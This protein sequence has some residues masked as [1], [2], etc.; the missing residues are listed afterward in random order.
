MTG[1]RSSIRAD[2]EVVD[3]GRVYVGAEETRT[4]TLSAPG[5]LPVSYSAAFLGQALGFR[6]GPASARVAANGHLELTITFAPKV[7]A[8]LTPSLRLE[9]DATETPIVE[10]ALRGTGVSP[11][12]CEDG[13]GCTL[14]RFDLA[15]RRCVHE[16]QNWACDDLNPCTELD[17]CVE[18]LC[19]GVPRSCD[20]ENGCTD[21]VCD[22]STGC[23]HLSTRSCDD[24]NPCT[25]D[26]C[27]A[28][29]DCVHNDAELGTVCDSVVQCTIAGICVFGNCKTVD[30]PEG[31]PCDD[32]DPCTQDEQC[33]DHQCIQ[34]GYTPAAV[35]EVKFVTDVGPLA[36]TAAENPIIDRDGTVFLGLK[37]AIT[38]VD[39]CGF[40]G[41]T[42]ELDDEPR[43]SGAVALPGVLSVPVGQHVVDVDTRSGAV[44]GL[45]DLGMLFE[46]PIET[47]TTA[48]TTVEVVDLALRA[49]G[50]MMASVVRRIDRPLVPSTADSVNVETTWE[51]IIA[52]IDR[53]HR[54]ASVFLALGHRIA[55]R[56]A[57]DQ[58]ESI[59]A[60]LRETSTDE[61][62]SRELAVR[63][64][65]EGLANNSWAT[66]ATNAL[67]SD[68]A[69]SDR[70]RVFWSG[71][72]RRIEKDG[73]MLTLAVPTSTASA[74]L[75]GTPIL[76][77]EQLFIVGPASLSAAPDA[78]GRDDSE[79]RIS[80]QTFDFSG[81]KLWHFEPEKA[82]RRIAPALDD[83]GT[84]FLVDDTPR[85]Y[86][87]AQRDGSLLFQTDLPGT[88]ELSD[89]V[90]LGVTPG[91]IALVILDNQVV[92]V[93]ALSG[94]AHTAWPRHRRD[95][96]S[97]GHR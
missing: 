84:V 41:W 83:A 82:R 63:I 3:F 27:D 49:S 68:I 36:S 55:T 91:G 12:D 28:E 35:G 76:G 80:L 79:A 38:A 9:A 64:G 4:V 71:G 57:I 54:Q 2:L 8:T 86:A 16:A 7:D 25:I 43:W 5:D 10:I 1:A 51:G 85:L 45:I 97:T 53:T 19:Q 62:A 77:L 46:S 95:N 88:F 6:A 52:E 32:G 58:D 87:L 73:E 23:L 75:T 65:I 33:I 37:R 59:L 24:G 21:D 42:T 34:P 29:G 74:G 78:L 61:A 31:T 70:G 72:L 96:L 26:T 20:D 90:S 17:T 60:I 15:E 67:R 13:N 94:L 66:S 69:I 22:P 56:V 89:A 93:R 11:P 18:G 39:Q 47:T 48:T 92:G 30:I 81:Q 40:R 50:A 14:D 44:L